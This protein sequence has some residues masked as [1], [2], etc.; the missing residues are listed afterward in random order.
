MTNYRVQWTASA[1]QDLT[2]IIQ[3]IAVDNPIEAYRQL[4]KIEDK[5]KQ[6]NQNPKRGRTVPELMAIGMPD[7]REL[8]IRPWRLI[9]RIE[10]RNVFVLALL[11]SRRNLEDILLERLLRPE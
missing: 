7:Y 5:A 1:R 11:D 4:E 2:E 6:L 3:F 10:N 8:I 9:Y